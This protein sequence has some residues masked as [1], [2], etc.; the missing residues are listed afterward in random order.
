M[1]IYGIWSIFDAII[2]MAYRANAKKGVITKDI[3]TVLKD[4]KMM[5]I[6]ALDGVTSFLPLK[7]IINTCK[8]YATQS[9]YWRDFFSAMAESWK[10]LK[11]SNVF[12]SFIVC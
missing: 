3:V 9:N 11:T 7:Y 2:I 6:V 12:S 4:C 8:T 1:P 10:K 5:S